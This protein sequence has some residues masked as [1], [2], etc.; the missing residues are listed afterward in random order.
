MIPMAISLGYGLVFATAI[1]LILIPSLYMIVE[2]FRSL[3]RTIWR[4]LSGDFHLS[5]TKSPSA[6]QAS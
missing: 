4:F 5:E 1:I 2:D 6:S 3:L